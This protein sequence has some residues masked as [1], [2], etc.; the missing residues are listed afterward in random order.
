MLTSISRARASCVGK[1]SARPF[2]QTQAG[3]GFEFLDRLTDGRLGHSHECRRFACAAGM[4]DGPKDFNISCIHY[5]P[6][7]W[8]ESLDVM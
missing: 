5:K 2:E 3:F 8:N 1:P 7:F 4:H 6:G